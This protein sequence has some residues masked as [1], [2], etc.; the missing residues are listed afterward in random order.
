MA[1]IELMMDLTFDGVYRDSRLSTGFVYVRGSYEF[2][3]V[4]SRAIK[5]LV[6][7]I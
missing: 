7:L 1:V 2:G 3:R 6:D 5:N 4:L